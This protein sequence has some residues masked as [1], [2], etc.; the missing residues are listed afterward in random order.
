MTTMGVYAL[1]IDLIL[2]CMG[3]QRLG[4]WTSL[5]WTGQ[6]RRPTRVR[7]RQYDAGNTFLAGM[8]ADRSAVIDDLTRSL[9][10]VDFVDI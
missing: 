7:S 5:S 2:R 3:T 1:R 8:Y 10:S 9:G 6:R 4:C